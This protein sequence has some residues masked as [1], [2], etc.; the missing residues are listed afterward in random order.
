MA[1]DGDETIRY[2]KPC[3]D[4][5]K[6]ID[7][8]VVPTLLTSVYLEGASTITETDEIAAADAM[9]TYFSVDT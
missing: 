8:S 3:Q 2:P 4:T 1:G 6:V 5:L 7:L 9:V